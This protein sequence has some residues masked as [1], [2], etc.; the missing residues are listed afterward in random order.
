[1][2]TRY[3]FA[4]RFFQTNQ[5]PS[6]PAHQYIISGTSTVS[7]GSA[8]RAADNPFSPLGGASGGCDSPI[9]SFVWL[10]DPLG[11][12]N[13]A[14]YPCFERRTLMDLLA[15]KSLSWRYYQAHLGAG[16]WEGPDAIAHLRRSKE[17]S[18]HVV[19]PPKLFLTDVARGRLANVVWVTPTA[20][21]SD[22]ASI[23]NGSGPS[24]VASVVNAIGMSRYWQNTAIFVTWDDWGG[25]YDHVAPPLYNSY[26][27]GFRV[28]LIVISPYVKPHYVSHRRHEFGSILRFIEE[29]FETGSLRTTDVRS[30]DLSDCFDF[31]QPPLR[32]SPIHAPLNSEYFMRQPASREDPDTD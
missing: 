23:T 21:A 17:F 6:F 29:T 4:D 22:H 28:P 14:A 13:Q 31:L 11:N 20:L 12:E 27:L 30:D 18:R 25:W 26:E 3:A 16:L 2:A 19:A 7:N 5:G 24:W 8:L 32:F 1:M 10:I 9:G 15:A